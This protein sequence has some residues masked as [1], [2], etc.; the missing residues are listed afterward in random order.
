MPSFLEMSDDDFLK[1]TPPEVTQVEQPT[2][3]VIEQPDPVVETPVVEATATEVETPTTVETP[4]AEPIASPA[5]EAPAVEQPTAEAPTP[6]VE[7]PE[8]E[9][10]KPEPTAATPAAE[11]DYKA[12]YEQIMAPFKAN[13]KTI[14]LRS[15]DEAIKLMQMGAN[16]TKNMQMLAPHRK[17][18]VMLEKAGINESNVGLLIDAH[19][20][21]PQAI[22]KMVKDAGVDPMDIDTSKEPQYVAGQH[23][24]SDAEVAWRQSI[25]ELQGSDEGQATLVHVN[26]H[27]DNGSKQLLAENPG[28]LQSIHAQRVSGIYDRIDTEI[29]R[30][31]TLGNIPAGT[32]YLQAYKTVGEYLQSNGGFDDLVQKPV[33]TAAQPAIKLPVATTVKK[34]EPQVKPNADV[35]AATISRTAPVVA[36]QASNFLAMSDDDFLKQFQNRL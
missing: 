31:R 36:K 19:N 23:N 22:A 9:E 35:G 17:L 15:P 16:Y 32:P 1:A 26:Q 33:Q 14:E 13:G 6:P 24:V 5:V 29:Q 4:A 18:L 25:E 21:N 7:T 11:V 30:L 12:G 10:K 2:P 8:K 3:E 34:A 28:L 27:W 20:K